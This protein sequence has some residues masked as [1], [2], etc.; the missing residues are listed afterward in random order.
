MICNFPLH[1]YLIYKIYKIYKS[2]KIYKIY[3]PQDISDTQDTEGQCLQALYY[4]ANDADDMQLPYTHKYFWK[5]Y[6][7]SCLTVL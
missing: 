1:K 6:G 7:S 3:K 2:Y 4:K 5:S